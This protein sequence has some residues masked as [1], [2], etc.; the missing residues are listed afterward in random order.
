MEY[1]TH[2]KILKGVGGLYAIKLV[3]EKS[4]YEAFDIISAYG[5]QIIC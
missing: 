2:G 1:R 5:T 3:D 4:H